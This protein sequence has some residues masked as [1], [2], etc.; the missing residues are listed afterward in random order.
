MGF[1]EKSWGRACVCVLIV[2]C[3]GGAPADDSAPGDSKHTRWVPAF[4]F[5]SG[6]QIRTYEGS[7]TDPKDVEPGVGV[8]GTERAVFAYVGASAEISSPK[9][10]GA[11]GPRVFVHVDSSLSF[12]SDRPIAGEGSPG[13]IEYPTTPSGLMVTTSPITGMLGQGSSLHAESKPLVVSAGTGLSFEFKALGRTLRLKPSVEWL[14]QETSVK[15]AAGYLVSTLEVNGTPLC[16][17]DVIRNT[18]DS[19]RPCATAFFGS[20]KTKAFHSLGPGLEIELDTGRVGPV[21]FALYASGQ[22]YRVLGNREFNL[23]ASAPL[24]IPAGFNPSG[25][26]P[27]SLPPDAQ[28]PVSI[29]STFEVDPWQYRFGVG[30]R[31]RWLPE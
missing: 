13:P 30:L 2:V 28:D 20:S 24:E 18:T 1:D 29:S 23:D 8:Q 19:P 9:L 27:G 14:W 26:P 17:L 21:A 11:R 25:T 12:D 4:S 5:F 31:F 7:V 10:L 6:A 15:T 3:A 16:S 22:A